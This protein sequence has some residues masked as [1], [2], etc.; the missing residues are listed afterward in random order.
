[1]GGE[2]AATTWEFLANRQVKVNGVPYSCKAPPAAI[3][4]FGSTF[5]KAK[6]ISR[7]VMQALES[8]RR[9]E[10]KDYRNGLVQLEALYDQTVETN[11][12]IVALTAEFDGLFEPAGLRQH[13][14]NEQDISLFPQFVAQVL[15]AFSKAEQEPAKEN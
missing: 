10:W 9:G 12:R 3:V 13:F 6:S 7:T 15:I 5:S 11:A 14:M 8:Y 2:K 1:M 4:G